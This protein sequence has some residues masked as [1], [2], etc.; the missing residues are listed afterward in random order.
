MH[1]TFLQQQAGYLLC[2]L[3]ELGAGEGLLTGAL[4]I[5][6]REQSVVS[7]GSGS[8]SQDL[9]NKLIFLAASVTGVILQTSCS[10]H[11][12]KVAL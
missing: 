12:S 6:Q 4:V 9:S 3:V 11:V 5:E 7:C 1:L 2:L 10:Q 8:P